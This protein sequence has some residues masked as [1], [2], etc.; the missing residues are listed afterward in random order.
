MEVCGYDKRDLFIRIGL[1]YPCAGY[2]I[3]WYYNGWHHW[4]FIAGEQ[5]VITE[6]E[7]YRT[8]GK[9]KI[10]I[11]TGNIVLSEVT[12]IRTILLST[13]IQIYT[14][15]GWVSV[16]ID[17]SSM[18]IYDNGIN[19]YEVELIVTIGSREISYNGYSPVVYVPIVPPTPDPDL[20]E[21]VIGT[22]IW[23]CKNYESKFPGSAVF[24]NDETNR[25]IYG[26]IY[27]WDHIMTPGFTPTG[28]RVPSDTDW[29]TL[30]A[31]LG[32]AA[33]AGGHL[34]ESGLT[35]WLN[36]NTD[37]DNSSGF[38]ARGAGYW[39]YT[40][41][42]FFGLKE[43]SRLFSLTG[44]LAKTVRLEYDSASVS[45]EAVLRDWGFPVRLIKESFPLNDLD[46]NGYTSIIIGTQEWIIE[47]FRCTK[48]A[49]GT[50]IPNLADDTID[51]WFL[52]S[53]DLLK[54]AYD[55]LHAFGVG[56]FIDELY[57]TSTEDSASWSRTVNFRTGSTGVSNKPIARRVRACRSFVAGAGDYA[58]RD[59]G[60]AGGLICYISGTTYYEA[61]PEDQSAGKAWSNI[62]STLIGTTGTAIGTGQANTAAII[63]QAGHIDSAAKLCDDLISGGWEDDTEGAYCAYDND[64]ANIAL[65]GLLY[66][67][68][69]IDNALELAYLER[70]GVQEIGWRVPTD[71]DFT[72]LINLLGGEAV[73]G[74]KLKEIGLVHWLTPNTGATDE[75]GF[76]SLPGGYRLDDGSFIGL[77]NSAIYWTSLEV[78]AD[79][80]R[81]L[82]MNYD[83][84]DCSLQNYLKLCG[85]SVRLVRDV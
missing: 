33:V 42:T 82:T 44:V 24:N 62:V 4:L 29:N 13:E 81:Y 69:A 61:A 16:Y 17:P 1:K 60:Q 78:D 80:A 5:N 70:N 45:F 76:K 56:G 46:L 11:G 59:L 85:F 10:G 27:K 65:Y 39:N 23:A 20:C 7:N 19:G 34:K 38:A 71:A 35:H 51:D 74:G 18:I 75:V 28:W 3:R 83:D 2:Y 53:V 54:A 48:Y 66:N 25:D 36:P 77:F 40:L 22:Q 52:P 68:F 30:I 50:V 31:F 57:W 47:N 84:I 67:W 6:G 37:A 21:M 26:G 49:D 14:D 64:T 63:G 15:T 41:G 72:T 58:L 9:R 55:N 73:A 32:G 43:V 8:L 79:N 12:A